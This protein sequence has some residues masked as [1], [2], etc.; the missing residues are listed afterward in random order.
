M[1]E[2]IYVGASYISLQVQYLGGDRLKEVCR[3]AGAPDDQGR[4]IQPSPKEDEKTVLK[5]RRWLTVVSYV[6][7]SS[8]WFIAMCVWWDMNLPIDNSFS[9]HLKWCLVWKTGRKFHNVIMN[10]HIWANQKNN[11]FVFWRLC[12]HAVFDITL[13]WLS[14]TGLVWWTVLSRGNLAPGGE[15]LVMLKYQH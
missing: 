7:K 3:Q 12:T 1:L 15:L 4:E 14:M 11:D 8:N 2:I 6:C 13:Q 5:A 10:N 9:D